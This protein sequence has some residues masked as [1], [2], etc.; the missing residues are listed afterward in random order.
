MMPNL[1][2]EQVMQLLAYAAAIGPATVAPA[3]PVELAAKCQAWRGELAARLPHGI[4]VTDLQAVIGDYYATPTDRPIQVG[5]IIARCRARRPQ[6]E[7]ESIRAAR[8]LGI[9]ECEHGEPKG[10]AACAICRHAHRMIDTAD[11]R[12]Q[13]DPRLAAITRD[14][15]RRDAQ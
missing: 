6:T 2:N 7:A 8:A 11:S 13:I 12:D 5:D 15:A 4:T 9:T 3:N 10:S 14:I 1:T